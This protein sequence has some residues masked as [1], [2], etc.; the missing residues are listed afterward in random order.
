MNGL[1]SEPQAQ[2][3]AL[4]SPCR[5]QCRT[6]CLRGSRLLRYLSVQPAA[7]VLVARTYALFHLH[8]WRRHT[9]TLTSRTRPA[10]ALQS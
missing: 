4:V 8:A 1:R 9:W 10:R 5:A 2:L 6:S 3:E 7:G